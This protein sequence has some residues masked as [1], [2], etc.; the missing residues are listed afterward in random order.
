[1]S[2]QL[3]S[4]LTI[5]QINFRWK[6]T[7]YIKHSVALDY[8]LLIKMHVNYLEIGVFEHPLN[9]NSTVPSIT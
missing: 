7:T 4:K 9:F 2:C 6:N 1:M 5:F 3:S 8:N